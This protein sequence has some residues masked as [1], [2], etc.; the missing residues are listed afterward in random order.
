MEYEHF[1]RSG[2]T[3]FQCGTCHRLK[4]HFR[5]LRSYTF[6]CSHGGDYRLVK[7]ENAKCTFYKFEAPI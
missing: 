6:K 2:L 7:H 3:I 1:E 4:L 5:G